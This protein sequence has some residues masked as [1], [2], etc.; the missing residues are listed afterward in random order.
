MPALFLSILAPLFLPSSVLC[1]ISFFLFPCASV[2]ES[3]SAWAILNGTCFFQTVLL[4]VHNVYSDLKVEIL[5][6][7][8]T[9]TSKLIN[10]LSDIYVAVVYAPVMWTLQFV[11]QVLWT[12]SIYLEAVAIL[13]QLFMVS[14]TGEAESITSHYLFALGSYRALY[15]VNWVSNKEMSLVLS[16]V[17]WCTF[18]I[19]Q[20]NIWPTAISSA[21]KLGFNNASFQFSCAYIG[22]LITHV[23]HM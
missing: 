1:L 12:F 23:K 14:K 2:W 10:V 18:T 4:Q 9:W 16:C 13:P 11:P 15:I 5:K 22:L 21:N 8:K 20:S 6:H 7:S 3:T 17:L 19:R